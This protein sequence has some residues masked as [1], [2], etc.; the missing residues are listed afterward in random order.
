MVHVKDDKEKRIKEFLKDLKRISIKHGVAIETEKPPYP[1]N[2]YQNITYIT[3]P[4][5]KAV[6]PVWL[7]T[8][9]DPLL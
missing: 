9:K 1:M 4:V 6:F 7:D 5:T 3:N 2:T 8:K